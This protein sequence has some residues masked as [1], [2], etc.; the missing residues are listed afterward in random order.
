MNLRLRGD[1]GVLALADAGRVFTAG[2]RSSAWH[3]AYGGGL[4]VRLLGGNQT[5]GATY[6]RG[7]EHRLYLWNGFL[8]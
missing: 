8:F 4:W 6:A 3:T 7:D 1:L 5:L 2:E